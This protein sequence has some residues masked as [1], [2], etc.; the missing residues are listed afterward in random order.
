MNFNIFGREKIAVHILQIA[1]KIPYPPKDGGS[2]AIHAIS[3]GLLNAGQYL[4]VLAVNSPKLFTNIDEIDKHYI[5]S[6]HFEAVEIDT[7]IKPI[8]A[9]LN[10]FSSS[11]YNIQRFDAPPFHQKLIEILRNQSFDIVHLESVFMAPY[12]S[13]IRKFSKAKI[14]LRAHNVEHKIWERLAFNESNSIKKWYLNLLATRLKN[15]ELQ[16]LN[17]YD[18]IAAISSIEQIELKTLGCKIPICHIPFAMDIKNKKIESITEEKYSVFSLAAMDWQPNIEGVNWFL[19]NVWNKIL[20]SIPNAK[21]YVAG[22]NMS[23]EW[24]QKK[25]RNV[26]MV[27]EVKNAEQFVANKSV[28][29]VPLFSGGGVRIKIIEG[30]AMQ[31]AM[32]STAIGA[33]G[34]QY[35]NGVHLLEAN[36]ADTF[37]ANVCK[38]LLNDVERKQL[39]ENARKHAEVFYDIEPATQKLINFYHQLISTQ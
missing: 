9:F 18:G 32:V 30:F 37:A 12:V 6:T 26:E 1:N 17:N 15:Y 24:M 28:M 34:I 35:K 16:M 33:E 14:V 3:K 7:R 19:E 38:L 22:R 13:T 2:L 8:D 29:I 11:S 27:G 21:F 5:D 20:Q 10:L 25:Y 36:D 31:K 23:K 4:K 39:A